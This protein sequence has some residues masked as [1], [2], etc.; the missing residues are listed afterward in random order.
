MV[1][2]QKSSL[3]LSYIHHNFYYVAPV[4]DCGF[5]PDPSNGVVSHPQGTEE[6]AIA[7]YDCDDEFMLTGSPNRQCLPSGL[8]SGV[9]P[10]CECKIIF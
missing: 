9:E 8:W 5:L 1:S 3:H 2:W 6:G 7:E 4:V 10:T